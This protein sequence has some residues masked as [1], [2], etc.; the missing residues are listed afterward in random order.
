M[1]AILAFDAD[2]HDRKAFDCGQPDLNRYLRE[3]ARQN[4]KAGIAQVF[5]LP[6]PVQTHRIAGFYTLSAGQVNRNLFPVAKARRLP[7]Y[8]IPVARLGR[9]AVDREYQNQKIG[10]RLMV[11]AVVQSQRATKHIGIHALVVDAKDDRV[12][13]YYRRF[14]FIPFDGHHL[15]LFL[16]LAMFPSVAKI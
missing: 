12:A 6:D 8:D 13:G 9:L 7:P 4:V 16:P 5:V 15:N 14:G 3:N 2:V 11:D 10:E 1:T